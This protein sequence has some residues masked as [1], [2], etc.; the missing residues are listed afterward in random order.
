MEK[1]VVDKSELKE[2]LDPVAYRV[3]QEGSTERPY[4]NKYYKHWEDGIYRC[5][6]CETDLFESDTKYD[7]GSGWP[8]FYDI[9]DESKITKRSD[10]S[11]VGG[12]IL[13]I[14]ANPHLIRTE[15]L[16][17]RCGSHLGHVFPDGP[18]PTGKRYCINSCSLNFKA[19]SQ[20]KESSPI[21]AD[22]TDSSSAISKAKAILSHPATIDGCGDNGICTLRNKPPPK[23]KKEILKHPATI[24]GCGADG[25]CTLRNKPPKNTEKKP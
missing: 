20:S 21:I 18:K 11:A 16:C 24:D 10:T 17:K 3:T 1:F 2:R 15:V 22:S 7:S 8:S 6:V 9:V 14:V 19:E 12:N 5:V 4:S 25:I 23:V 13:R